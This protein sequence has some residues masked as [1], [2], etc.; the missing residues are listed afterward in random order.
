MPI[1]EPLPIQGVLGELLASLE[2]A[3]AAVLVAP[4]GAGKT[5]GVPLALLEATWRGDDRIIVAE[6]RRVATRMAAQRLASQ[7]DER[8]GETIGYRTRDDTVV[9]PRTRVEVVTEVKELMTRLVRSHLAVT[10]ADTWALELCCV[11][12]PQLLLPTKQTHGLRF[13]SG[14]PRSCN[15]SSQRQIGGDESRPRLSA[16]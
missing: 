15:L 3:R 14:C 10:S 2:R 12:I 6:P 5:T 7:L 16:P 1:G 9:G 11:G 4:P 8:V 13:A